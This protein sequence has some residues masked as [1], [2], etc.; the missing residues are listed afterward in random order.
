MRD[1]PPQ[2]AKLTTGLH[3]FQQLGL[4]AGA[5]LQGLQVRCSA[6]RARGLGPPLSTPLPR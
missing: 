1:V 2:M 5:L 4:R 6:T 3:G